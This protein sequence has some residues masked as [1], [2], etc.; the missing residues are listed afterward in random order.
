[1]KNLAVEQVSSAGQTVLDWP[2]LTSIYGGP[3]AADKDMAGDIVPR[4]PYY[5]VQTAQTAALL[6]MVQ[7]GYLKV[8]SQ[9]QSLFSIF[10][11]WLSNLARQEAKLG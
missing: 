9:S 4:R 11:K 3:I 6:P 1:M 7:S 10:I 2:E 8:H 5:M